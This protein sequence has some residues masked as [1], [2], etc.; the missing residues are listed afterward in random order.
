MNKVVTKKDDKGEW[1]KDDMEVADEDIMQML[2]L[3]ESEEVQKVLPPSEV[4]E[5]YVV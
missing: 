3:E 5:G 1:D 2:E 4:R